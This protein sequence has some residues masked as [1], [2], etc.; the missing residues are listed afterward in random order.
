MRAQPDSFGALAIFPARCVGG[1][2]YGIKSSE[3]AD[4]VCHRPALCGTYLRTGLV[5]LVDCL[6]AAVRSSQLASPGVPRPQ[7]VSVQRSIPLIA[8]KN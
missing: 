6:I 3:L 5:G 7:A 8:A 2:G 1:S 4:S